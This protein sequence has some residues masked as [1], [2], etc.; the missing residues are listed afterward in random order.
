MTGFD[1]DE[2]ARRLLIQ[3]VRRLAATPTDLEQTVAGLERELA[4]AWTRHG[5]LTAENVQLREQLLQTQRHLD[6]ARE[7]NRR[8]TITDELGQAE[9]VLLDRLLARDAVS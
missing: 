7:R 8:L 3:V 6:L 5:A 4:A 9:V 2:L 1:Y